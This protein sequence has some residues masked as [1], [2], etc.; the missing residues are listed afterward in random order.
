MSIK[1]HLM[2]FGVGLLV[3]LLCPLWLPLALLSIPVLWLCQLGEWGLELVDYMVNPQDYRPRSPF[4]YLCTHP[5]PHPPTHSN[6][7]GTDEQ[8]T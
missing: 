7:A 6:N 5:T 3:I 1:E 2:N 8:L 4:D